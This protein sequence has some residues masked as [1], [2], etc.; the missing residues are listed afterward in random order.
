[1]RF[2]GRSKHTIQMNSKAAGEGYKSYSFC[3]SNGHIIDFKFS[4]AAEKVAKLEQ[5]SGFTHNKTV[6]LDFADSVFS[7]L[8]TAKAILP[9]SSW[10]PLHHLQALSRAF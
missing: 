6:V 1:M 4:R 3:C 8:S 7:T 5:Y 2:K 9:P 10:Q